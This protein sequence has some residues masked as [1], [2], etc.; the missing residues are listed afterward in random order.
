[1]TELDLTAT[2][3]LTQRLAGAV[4]AALP[5]VGTSA[6][7]GAG[8]RADLRRGIR[9][10]LGQVRAAWRYLPGDLSPTADLVLARTLSLYALHHQHLRARNPHQS[11]V[12]L[13]R[14]YAAAVGRGQARGPDKVA[15]ED[16]V[17][18]RLVR[19]ATLEAAT[20]HLVRLVPM[21]GKA[22]TGLDYVFLARDLYAV[23]AGDELAA[24]RVRTRWVRQRAGL[25]AA[26]AAA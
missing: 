24:R 11:G 13:G 17:F 21:L 26:A 6:A 3:A 10:D 14:A 19:V 4:A 8:V 23:A 5:Q 15:R 12:G 1:M 22:G 20:A 16:A 18:A 2:A 25:P 9:R 7:W